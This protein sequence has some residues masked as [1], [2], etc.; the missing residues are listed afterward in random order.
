MFKSRNMHEL[1]AAYKGAYRAQN[2]VI[3]NMY[4]AGVDVLYKSA[5]M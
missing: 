1:E 2:I 3:Q 4:H 5:Y